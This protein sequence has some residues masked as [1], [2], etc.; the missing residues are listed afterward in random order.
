VRFRPAQCREISPNPP[1]NFLT[2]FTHTRTFLCLQKVLGN[3]ILTHTG[4]F[5]CLQKVLGKQCSQ[6]RAKTYAQWDSASGQWDI[7]Y[8][9][10]QVNFAPGTLP[11]RECLEK[12]IV[13]MYP[14][15]TPPPTD[16]DSKNFPRFLDLPCIF[17]QNLKN[18]MLKNV[19]EI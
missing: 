5:L 12:S 6:Y 2:N 7:G 8:T 3:G 10:C 1:R 9:F 17:S 14:P 16:K 11:T 18:P 4:T 13:P 19:A 15:H